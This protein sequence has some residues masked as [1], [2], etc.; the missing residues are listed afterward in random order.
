MNWW[1]QFAPE[2]LTQLQALEHRVAESG[3]PATAERYVDA[4]VDFCVRLQSFAA[5]GVS[6]DDLLPA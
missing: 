4:I 1:V 6:R 5:C 2:A 3:A